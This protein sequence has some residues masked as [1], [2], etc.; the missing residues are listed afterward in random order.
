MTKRPIIA[1]L[2]IG[3]TNKKLFFFDEQYN[4]VFEKSE[5]FEETT[6]EDGDPC[7][8]I[9][10]LT[11][12]VL[13][14][15]DFALNH[16]VFDVKIINFA[17]Y[18]ASFV[19]IG[20]DGKPVAPLYNYLKPFPNELKE[21]FYQKYEGE[22]IGRHSAGQHSTIAKQTASPVLGNL[23]SGMQ[24]YRLKYAK[25]DIFNKVK[26]AL[27]LPQYVSYLITKQ[28]FSELTSIGCH[29]QLWDFE[30]N[31][32]H[33]WVKNEKIDC[34]LA[35][36]VPSDKT[37]EM[38]FEGRKIKVG[39]GLHDSSAAL[40]PYLMREDKPFVLI[41]TGTWCISLNPFNHNALTHEDL[42]KDCLCFMS[43]EGK[44]V[45]ASRIF[46]GNKHSVGLK[47][48]TKDSDGLLP[49][50]TIA[51]KKLI[52]EIVNEQVSST[53]LVIEDNENIKTIFVDGGF[54]KNDKYIQ[55]LK[56]SFPNIKIVA[57][58]AAGWQSAQATALG[59]AL[60]Y[61]NKP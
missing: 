49:T 13:A 47:Q 32:Y 12:W 36:I 29:T 24:L 11:A 39:V 19:L 60:I 27:H 3:K 50:E 45:K 14:A 43:Y 9:D 61:K 20:E 42:T 8:D 57:A 2:D 17:A 48:I 44:S 22:T 40:I 54:A 34:I 21:R 37:T 35:P 31:D 18:G 23:N 1:I 28:A 33:N 5:E 56:I 55:L 46:A 7:E 41:S 15:V 25:P 26:Y 52:E 38:F 4:V 51:Y 30:K 59:A 6:D 10:K 53:K 16:A 58:E